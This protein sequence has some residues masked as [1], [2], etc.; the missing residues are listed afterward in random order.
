MQEHGTGLGT[1]HKP[2]EETVQSFGSLRTEAIAGALYNF[3]EYREL[4]GVGHNRLLQHGGF[5]TFKRFIAIA[6]R[7][8]GLDP[9]RLGD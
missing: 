8:V 9:M 4:H 3:L 5:E 7:G 6:F 2:G 1:Q